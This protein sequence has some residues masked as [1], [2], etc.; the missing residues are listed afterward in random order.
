MDARGDQ[1]ADDRVASGIIRRDGHCL[2]RFPADRISR[3][4]YSERRRWKLSGNGD[5]GWSL[6]VRSNR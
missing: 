6:V 5:C 1:L 4:T 2:T 3:I